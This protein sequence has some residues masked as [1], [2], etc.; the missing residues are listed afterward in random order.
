MDVALAPVPGVALSG[1]FSL[2]VNTTTAAALGLP[3][4][5]YLRLDATGAT[6]TI[7]GQ[8]VSGN[9]ALVSATNS[10]GASV[11]TV[12]IS[13][14]TLSPGR[15]ADRQQRLRPDA[16]VRRIDRRHPDRLASPWTRA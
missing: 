11:L 16:A 14:G 1:T 13:N 9:L 10:A 5:P 6:L 4:G 2:D 12:G 8:T 15:R 3:A 7:L